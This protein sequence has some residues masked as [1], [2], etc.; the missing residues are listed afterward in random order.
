[1]KLVKTQICL[2]GEF[3]AVGPLQGKDGRPV[4]QNEN[5]SHSSLNQGMKTMKAWLLKPQKCLAMSQ[6]SV[7]HLLNLLP[8]CLRCQA[9]ARYKPKQVLRT[10]YTKHESF[11]IWG[12]D[13]VSMLAVCLHE[14]TDRYC[15]FIIKTPCC[16][17]RES[18]EKHCEGFKLSCAKLML[19]LTGTQTN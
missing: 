6:P 16:L 3:Q 13:I 15:R 10:T 2:S 8:L 18:H 14:L 19:M 17:V 12:C 11:V 5:I 7:T 1:M 4:S 9:A